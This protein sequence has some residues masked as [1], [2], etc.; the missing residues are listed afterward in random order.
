MIYSMYNQNPNSYI[1]ANTTMA[2]TNAAGELL[3]LTTAFAAAED[4][5][6]EE[7]LEELEEP[8]GLQFAPEAA[9]GMEL[10]VDADGARVDVTRLPV[11]VVEAAANVDSRSATLLFVVMEVHLPSIVLRTEVLAMAAGVEPQLVYCCM[12]IALVSRSKTAGIRS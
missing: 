9:A 8:D 12:W 6:A 10:A 4:D 5:E 2:T 7:E 1:S 3:L 11:P